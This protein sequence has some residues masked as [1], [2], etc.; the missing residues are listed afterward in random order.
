MKLHR[1]SAIA[2]G[3][4]AAI[5]LVAV[6]KPGISQPKEVV[7]GVMYP[8][9]GNA[10]Q[11]GVDAVYAV[12]LATD[13]VNAHHDLTAIYPFELAAKDVVYP[14]PAWKDRK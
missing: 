9:S 8:L 5:G 12:K 4:P 7:I 3:L 2:L 6:S 11:V 13:I 1:R 14:L 10:A